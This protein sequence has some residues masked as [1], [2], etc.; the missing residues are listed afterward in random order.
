MS[1]APV[2]SFP[3]ANT[4]HSADPAV[5]SGHAPVSGGANRPAQPVSE[6]LSKKESSAAKNIP[7][8]YELPEDVVEVHQD[9]DIKSQ[10]IVEYLDSAKDVVLQVPSNQELAVERGISQEFQQA[11]KLRARDSTAAA[12]SERGKIHGN[13]L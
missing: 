12:V 4:E 10:V 1:I 2:A 13:K 9:P 6:T 7:A 5:G 11:A 8:T 3:P